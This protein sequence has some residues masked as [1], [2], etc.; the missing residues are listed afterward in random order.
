[1]AK[2]LIIIFITIFITLSIES[3]SVGNRLSFE[4]RSFG[5]RLSSRDVSSIE[6]TVSFAL[7]KIL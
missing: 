4:D 5:H 6:E 1:M 7:K 3:S 2:F